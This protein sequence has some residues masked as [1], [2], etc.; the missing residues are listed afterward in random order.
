MAWAPVIRDEG[1]TTIEVGA[2]GRAFVE[3]MLAACDT[4]KRLQAHE[5]S[6]K[7]SV[8]TLVVEAGPS[9]FD[10]VV[11]EV[12]NGIATATAGI[13]RRSNDSYVSGKTQ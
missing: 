6:P 13:G 9:Y 1:N 11:K 4:E 7:F 3:Q 5:L 12:G 10:S 8:E 2:G